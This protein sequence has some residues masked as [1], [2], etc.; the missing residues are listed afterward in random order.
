MPDIKGTL[1][2]ADNE[3]IQRWWT[4]HWKEPVVCPVCKTTEWTTAPHV[5][6][7]LRHAVDA[8]VNNTVSYP[9]I[10]V[11]CQSCAHSMFFNAVQIGVS[12][13]RQPESALSRAIGVN[14]EAMGGILGLNPTIPPR[15]PTRSFVGLLKKKDS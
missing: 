11:T 13:A 15:P 1:S 8:A 9:H 3:I 10:V 6:N 12:P 7:F 5:V 2:S 4:Q 14:T